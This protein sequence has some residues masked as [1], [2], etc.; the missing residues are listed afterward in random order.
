[1]RLEPVPLD[2]VDWSQVGRLFPLQFSQSGE[3]LRFA[4]AV[5]GGI[6]IVAQVVQGADLRGYF[7]GVVFRRFGLRI[8]GSPFPGWTLPYLGFTLG[9]ATDFAAALDGL[10][11]LAFR[12]L[13]CIHFELTDRT[14][15][16]EAASR[17]GVDF[18][19]VQGYLTDLTPPED[20]IFMTMT[21][22]CRRAVRKAEKCGVLIEEAPAEG[23]AAD[24]YA[25]L[26]D[27]FAKQ[28]LRPT[29]GVD[30]VETL[31]R[32]LHPTGGLLLLRARSPDGRS[33][34]TGIY[35]GG[36]SYSFFWGN[37]S[38]RGD[39]ILRPNEA[40][41]WHAIRTWK[42]RGSTRHD[43]GGAGDYK[44]KYGGVEFRV[45]S[46]RQSR[47]AAVSRAR[48][49]AKSSYYFMRSSLRRVRG[50]DPLAGNL[51]RKPS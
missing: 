51:E 8:L 46:I 3:W 38:L 14:I 29:Y 19:S 30:R 5:S 15:T 31:I 2:A 23:F 26:L 22:A 18:D 1:M 45:A 50:K 24:Y 48:N 27:V 16:P 7:F 11:D 13:S 34:A 9:D 43:W 20:A 4:A 6:P 47:Y 40:L 12:R 39:Q 32:F 28:G 33:I 35:P 25:H 10:R 44:R 41:H 36:R 21:S 37:G 49:V 17:L 42:A